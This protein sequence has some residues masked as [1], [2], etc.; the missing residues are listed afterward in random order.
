MRQL[1]PGTSAVI[2]STRIYGGSTVRRHG[3]RSKTAATSA[4]S[5]LR[6][7][8]DRRRRRL[9][10][11]RALPSRAVPRLERRAGPP[12][13]DH[14]VDERGLR[15]PAPSPL[16]RPA[17][18][19]PVP[20]PRRK[21]QRATTSSTL[22]KL[23]VVVQLRVPTAV[24]RCGRRSARAHPGRIAP[25]AAGESAADPAEPWN[26]GTGPKQDRS[27]PRES[28][29]KVVLRE[30]DPITQPARIGIRSARC[31]AVSEMSTATTCHRVRPATRIRA[32]PA[33]Q[34]ERRAGRQRY[35]PPQRTR[36]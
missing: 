35:G 9:P 29:R 5:V 24:A 36:R 26:E 20:I 33:P 3:G 16:G 15:R 4:S 13:N 1:A 34:I 18:H 2:A 22:G 12:E 32:L 7:R 10:A 14:V 6:R 31:S 11:V 28:Y 8:A 21:T 25:A 30:L 19:V 23:V 17:Q 27:R